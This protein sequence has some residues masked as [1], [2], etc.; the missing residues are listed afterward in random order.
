MFDG[1]RTNAWNDLTSRLCSGSGSIIVPPPTPPG[2][3][4][5]ADLDALIDTVKRNM[6]DMV[7]PDYF[8][9]S[10][11]TLLRY[12]KAV[13]LSKNW[14]ER[15]KSRMRRNERKCKR[16]RRKRRAMQRKHARGGR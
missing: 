5:L 10:P 15:A 11:I 2:A 12:E 4:T 16:R 1:L 14:M 7:D 3:I 13:R 8:F 9:V 6:A